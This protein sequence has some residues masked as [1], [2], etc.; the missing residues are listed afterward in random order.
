MTDLKLKT[1]RK[2]K[3]N[4]CRLKL[5]ILLPLHNILLKNIYTLILC[6]L[7]LI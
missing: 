2:N 5:Y 4:A 6:F 3:E 1:V 7:C